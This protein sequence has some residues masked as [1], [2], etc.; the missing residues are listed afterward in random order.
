MAIASIVHP[1]AGTLRF[2]TNPN[3][4]RWNYTLNTNVDETY[5]GRVVQILSVNIDELTV[6]AHAGRGG[7]PYVQQV[8][9]YFR[10]LLVAQRN[11]D[12]PAHFLYPNRGWDFAVYAQAIPLKDAW[13]SVSR[14]FTMQFA[15]Q[16]DVSG[17]AS[18]AT[19]DAE[20][21]RL[22]EGIGYSQN[23]YNTPAGGDPADTGDPNA[24]ATPTNDKGVNVP[25]SPSDAPGQSYRDMYPGLTR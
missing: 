10:D 11:T 25:Y 14:E 19:I 2:R 22:R 6:S 21:A 1:H 13:S 12:A 20:L 18:K 7:W 4:I 16:E 23:E 5:A 8:A 24:Q 15:V 17:L 9:L 3:S